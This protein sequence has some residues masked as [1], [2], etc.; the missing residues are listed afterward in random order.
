MLKCDVWIHPSCPSLPLV[1]PPPPPPLTNSTCLPRIE[2]HIQ[3]RAY[4]STVHRTSVRYSCV[5]FSII[6]PAFRGHDPA[7]KFHCDVPGCSASFVK[8]AHLRRHEMTHTQRRDFVCPSCARSFSRNDSMARHLRRKHPHLY[9]SPEAPV[10]S[11]A[12]GDR[13]YRGSASS[14]ASSSASGPT[15]F[16]STSSYSMLALRSPFDSTVGNGGSPAQRRSDDQRLLPDPTE[17]SSAYSDAYGRDNMP[18]SPKGASSAHWHPDGPS[19][20]TDHAFFAS[21]AP[22]VSLQVPLLSL[23]ST[24]TNQI[25][26]LFLILTGQWHATL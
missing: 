1:P 4:A 26:V 11:A 6:M 15:N 14:M 23:F 17:R 22:T 7:R 12:G 20:E 13:L 18:H 16:A 10:S 19:R 24:E 21:A 25:Y 5:C 2:N 3:S 8:R 9:R